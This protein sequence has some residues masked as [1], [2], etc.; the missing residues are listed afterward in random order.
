[1]T[2]K[3]IFENNIKSLIQSA[4][5]QQKMPDDKKNQILSQLI[6]PDN[7]IEPSTKTIP[8]WKLAL[9][10]PIAKLAAAAVIIVIL[11][12][13]LIHLNTEQQQLEPP[14]KITRP[15]LPPT[16]LLSM[17]LIF[18]KKGLKGLE[19]HLDKTFQTLNRPYTDI[20]LSDILKELNNH[21]NERI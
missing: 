8:I 5:P 18:Q 13:F 14:D 20:N 10:N 17:S 6:G 3:N 11:G 7:K 4:P 16:T 19:E 21:E 2:D 9:N 1:M 15:Q 12:L